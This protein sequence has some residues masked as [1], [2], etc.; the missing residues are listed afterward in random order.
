MRVQQG[1]TDKSSGIWM[2]D[3]I[4]W[5]ADATQLTDGV[6][7]F[8]ATITNGG[9]LLV[10]DGDKLVAINVSSAGLADSPYPKYRGNAANTGY[11]AVNTTAIVRSMRMFRKVLRCRRLIPTRSIRPP[12]FAL[13]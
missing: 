13:V 9:L 8:P 3:P 5:A 7:R 12:I 11:I 2:F 4:Q 6:P 10:G 1:E